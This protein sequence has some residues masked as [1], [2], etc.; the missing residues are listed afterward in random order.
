MNEELTELMEE[1]VRLGASYEMAFTGESAQLDAEV[2]ATKAAVVATF[3]ARE[4]I[5]KSLSKRIDEEH[6]LLIDVRTVANQMAEAL[7]YVIG[8][9]VCDNCLADYNECGQHDCR[10]GSV[11]AAA[12]L[13][14]YAALE[15]KG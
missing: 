10:E 5:I 9:H 8:Y 11:K 2:R 14:A 1:L 13:A 15:A 6:D 12:A 4:A 7:A 3:E